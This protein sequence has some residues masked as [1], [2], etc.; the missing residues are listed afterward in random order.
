M[1]FVYARGLKKAREH[2]FVG[3]G[4]DGEC[5]PRMPNAESC[6]RRQARKAVRS[7]V[8]TPRRRFDFPLSQRRAAD[9]P[10]AFEAVSESGERQRGLTHA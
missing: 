7:I 8:K 6:E 1:V 10:E 5:G 2:L 3:E 9:F 4:F